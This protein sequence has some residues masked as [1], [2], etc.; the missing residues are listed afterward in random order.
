MQ[1]D[2][3]LCVKMLL[4]YIYSMHLGLPWEQPRHRLTAILDLKATELFWTESTAGARHTLVL[5]LARTPP[6]KPACHCINTSWFCHFSFL[7]STF[8]THAR[9]F[10]LPSEFLL[11]TLPSA[12][13]MALSSC[14]RCFERHKV[15]KA[16]TAFMLAVRFEG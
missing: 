16:C 10:I 5:W 3:L 11:L 4:R 13:N 15:H 6:S 14:K 8:S 9:R 2:K 12:Q 1:L 7:I